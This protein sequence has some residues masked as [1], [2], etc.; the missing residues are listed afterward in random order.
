MENSHLLRMPFLLTAGRCVRP[1]PWPFPG[2]N[3]KDMERRQS[4]RVASGGPGTGSQA[5]GNIRGLVI[6]L[7]TPVMSDT[8][9]NTRQVLVKLKG[10]EG[11]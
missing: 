4:Q 3:P 11:P 9:Q 6:S 5:A 10:Q 7:G 1:S 2:P 8:E